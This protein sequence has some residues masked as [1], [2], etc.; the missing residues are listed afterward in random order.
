MSLAAVTRRSTLL[1]SRM[2]VIGLVPLGLV[3]ATGDVLCVPARPALPVIA[4]ELEA[5]QG[6]ASVR[7]KRTGGRSPRFGIEPERGRWIVPLAGA[8]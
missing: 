7:R 1:T 4:P 2:L 3:A 6:E 8:G 5:P